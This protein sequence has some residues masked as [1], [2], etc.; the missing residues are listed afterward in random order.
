MISYSGKPGETLDCL[1]NK[2]FCEKVATNTTFLHPKTLPPRWKE[3]DG[4]LMPLFTDL[5]PAP[6][7][8]LKIIRCN[9]HTDSSTMMCVYARSTM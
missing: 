4:I 7:D 1:R 6:H 8:I 9:R 5:A 3:C 2:Y